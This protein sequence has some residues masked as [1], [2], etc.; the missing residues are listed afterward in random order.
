MQNDS[1]TSRL[2]PAVLSIATLFLAS[3]AIAACS[4]VA[5]S[6]AGDSSCAALTAC[7]ETIPG[8]TSQ[9]CQAMAQ[10]ASSSA[11]GS[12]CAAVL[13]SYRADGECGGLD[14]GAGSPDGGSVVCEL[15]GTCEA[16]VSADAGAAGG[17]CQVIA[18]CADGETYSV[19]TQAGAGGSCSASVVFSDGARMACNSCT[20][21]AA[22]S[23]SAAVRCNQPAPLP[24][25]APPP[26][27]DSG[28]S[29][30]TSPVLHPETVPGV[31]CPFTAAGAV[32]CAAG[33]ECC[34]VPSGSGAFSTCVPAGTG[35]PIVGSLRWECVDPLDCIGTDAGAAC[36]ATGGTT[37]L[38]PVCSYYRGSGYTG[39]V[40][41]ASCGAGQT[42][43]C[44]AANDPCVSPATCT[45]F[46]AA[47]L[48]MGTCL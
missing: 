3:S 44:S 14:G 16:S 48:V 9:T 28:P 30:G 7:C 38:D 21:C 33:E 32:H 23:A 26:P 6:A 5:S 41:A 43:I 10:A 4:S 17:Q 47:G 34:E 8:E 35:C 42:T 18:S 39:A 1:F 36:C 12:S 19:C 25:A 24:D 15:S 31:Y 20:D 29:C 22:A 40:C 45:P 27:V 2:R 13:Q 37:T 11:S 46:K